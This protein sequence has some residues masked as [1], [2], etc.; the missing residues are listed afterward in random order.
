[1]KYRPDIDSLRAVA[2]GAV[3]L[4]HL[5]IAG[6]SGGFSGVDIFFV[7]SGFLITNFLLQRTSA[8]RISVGEFYFRRARRILPMALLV[9]AATCIAAYF[10]FSQLK[11]VQVATDSYWA[12][13]F[14]ANLR[15][16][17]Q[18]TD[19]F[20]HGFDQSAVQHYWSLA[21]EEQFYL[22]FPLLV[23]GIV[24]FAIKLGVP[25]W[26]LLLAWV[27]AAGAALS[28]I[29]SIWQGSTEPATAYFSSATRAYEIAIGALLASLTFERRTT[30][31]GK[32]STIAS[33]AAV[34]AFAIS[35]AALNDSLS[36]PSYLALLPTLGAAAFIWADVASNKVK[37][38]SRFFNSNAMVYLGK[39]SFSIYLVHWPLIIFSQALL[40]DLAQSWMFAPAII[41]VTLA[42][43]AL[44]YRFIEQPIRRIELPKA[45][46]TS[47]QRFLLVG[48]AT[49][50]I[51]AL[52]SSALAMTGGT[53]NTAHVAADPGSKTP[54][55]Y[56]PD[57]GGPTSSPTPSQSAGNTPTATP[58][59][60]S[61][62]G[63]SPS[64]KPT[65]KP[66]TPPEPPAEPHLHRCRQIL[67]RQS[68]PC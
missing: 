49:V 56:K 53:W 6:F 14:L 4:S 10:L 7:I 60:S 50:A 57:A 36:Y 44:G 20:T 67:T 40:P 21:V 47:K 30:S 1:M 52:T 27:I 19:Y 66:T 46:P 18:S 55:K 38:L 51:L 42:L 54:D 24:S 68:Q 12:A 11:A 25:N 32:F 16:I 64:V 29:W 41:A 28:L 37:M 31:G 63:P 15:L 5:G 13:L 58:T 61:S 22:V 39:I 43:S 48:A 33:F 34:A 35:F 9:L 2:V 23:I 17:Q 65:D 59:P 8:G 26:R 3:V 62:A 45:R